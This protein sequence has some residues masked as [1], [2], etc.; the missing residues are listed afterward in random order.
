[1][2]VCVC[3]LVGVSWQSNCATSFHRLPLSSTVNPRVMR[4]LIAQAIKMNIITNL[5]PLTPDQNTDSSTHTHTHLHTRLHTHTNEGCLEGMLQE[6]RREK[7]STGGKNMTKSMVADY[8]FKDF[9]EPWG[10]RGWLFLCFIT[11]SS[12]LT[13]ASGLFF[14]HNINS[15]QPV[16]DICIKL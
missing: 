10:C 5:A 11:D 14:E 3:G 8:D 13:A 1:M 7:K 12:Q 16:A 2:V 4:G 15:S 6:E 9:Q